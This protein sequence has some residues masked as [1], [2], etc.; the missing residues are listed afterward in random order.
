M[1]VVTT[2]KRDGRP[3]S[4]FPREGMARRILVPLDGSR[5]ADSALEQLP[6]FCAPGDEVTLL[7]VERPSSRQQVGTRQARAVTQFS[8]PS[9]TARLAP[10]RETPVFETPAQAR[11]RQ[12]AGLSSYLGRKAALVQS[13]GFQVHIQPIIDK[14]PARA[15]VDYA[16]TYRPSAILMVPRRWDPRRIF[17]SVSREV[18]RAGVAP[19]VL[20]HAGSGGSRAG[21]S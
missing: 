15:I 16:A 20:L 10:G 13:Q 18:E 2:G 17:R 14:D 6:Q 4:T 3:P 1:E 7:A 12:M 19:V 21:A 5:R 8:D 11:E 9:G